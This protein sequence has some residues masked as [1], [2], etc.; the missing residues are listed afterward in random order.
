MDGSNAGAD[1]GGFG[2]WEDDAGP[3]KPVAVAPA[4]AFRY[5]CRPRCLLTAGADV[6]RPR[7]APNMEASAFSLTELT[8]A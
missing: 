3:G 7:D 1:R 6:W 2:R 4:D 8:S 5:S